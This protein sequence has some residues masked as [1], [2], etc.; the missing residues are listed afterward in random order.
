[1]CL[2]PA[3]PARGPGRV[4][5]GLGSPPVLAGVC[6]ACACTPP[7]MAGVCGVC[8]S[9]CVLVLLGPV[10]GVCE[11]VPPPRRGSAVPMFVPLF[12]CLGFVARVFVFRHSW[13]G[14]WL[15]FVVRVRAPRQ[16]WLGF[17]VC[18][19]VPRHCWLGFVVCV[20]VPCHSWLGF[21]VCVLMPRHS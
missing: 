1:M 14:F 4:R 18:V 15:G 17:V 13:P 16:S 6:G 21:V 2:C 8:V 5:L 9:V 10:C 3:T 7:L 11:G 20:L 12:S 19:L